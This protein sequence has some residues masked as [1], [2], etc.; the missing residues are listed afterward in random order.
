MSEQNPSQPDA[1][2]PQYGQY[3]QGQPYPQAQYPAQGQYPQQGYPQ[4]YD[5]AAYPQQGGYP[6]PGQYTQPGQ[7]P[8]GYDPQA[9]PPAAY[10]QY[11]A[12]PVAQ[13]QWDTTPVAENK[14]LG[15]VGFAIVAVTA[16]VLAV[17]L[18]LVGGEVGAFMVDYGI[19]VAANP[20]PTDPAII[21]LSQQINGLSILATIA[22]VVGIVGWVVSIVA[23]VRRS[24]RR[25]GVWGIIVG[26]LAP[27]L[28]IVAMMAGLW[29][30]LAVL[31]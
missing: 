25:F 15:M 16:I 5:P 22:T 31:A 26:I 20:D 1:T 28:G 17:V 9:Y 12:Y 3:P 18:Y 21:A 30:H 2:P 14:M 10:G 29:P 11:P 4:S 24:G 27:V 8:Q 7:Y 19:D 6:Q 23:T 13:P